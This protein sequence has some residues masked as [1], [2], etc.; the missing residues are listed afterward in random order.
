MYWQ[1]CPFEQLTRE[2]LY[3]LLALRC[4]IFVVEQDCAYQDLDGLDILPDVLHVM[5][6]ERGELRAAGRILGPGVQTAEHVWIGRLV[7]VPAAR[8]QGLARV[9]MQ[10]AIEAATTHWPGYPLRL[11]G[12]VYIRDF[13]RSLG[14]VPVS[15]EYLEDGILHQDMELVCSE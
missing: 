7:V 15:D 5:A 8:G 2:Q 3:R 14:F 13:Y 12:Q 9:L 6:W 4:Q 10:Q 1:I 11:S